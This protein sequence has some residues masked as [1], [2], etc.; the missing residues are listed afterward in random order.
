MEQATDQTSAVDL[1]DEAHCL[2]AVEHDKAISA[3]YVLVE[4][5][6]GNTC[7]Y[8]CSY[9]PSHLHDGSVPWIDYAK[10]LGFLDRLHRHY[11]DGLG[12][13]IWLHYTGGEPT[14]YPDFRRLI[15][16]CANRGFKQSVIS[17]GVRSIKFWRE[18]VRDLDFVVL[19]C[20]VEFV[21]TG[22]F[23]S[24]VEEVRRH[25]PVHVNITM[26]PQRFDTCQE[27]ALE[28]HRRFEDVSLSLKPLRVDFGQQLYEYTPEQ[29]Q[30]LKTPLQTRRPTRDPTPRTVM[31]K[32]YDDGSRVPQKAN[33]FILSGENR[34]RGWRCAA[35]VESLHIKPDGQVFQALCRVGGAI[36]RVDGEVDFPRE[37]AVCDRDVCNCV[38]D[39]L[40]TKLR[41]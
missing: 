26:L 4:W 31:A 2:V 11:E 32:V 1:R 36:G 20:H 14:V 16:A 29:L 5:M 21:K 3:D 6:L 40:L 12:K 19:T 18:A 25:V 28:L 8:A 33:L 13:K 27:T 30:F 23:Y 41:P 10:V 24:V 35:G 9:C 22:H 17:N 15:R 39:I 34:W 38:S 7:T 37:F